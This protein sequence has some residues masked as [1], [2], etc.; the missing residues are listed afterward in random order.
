MKIVNMSQFFLFILFAG[1]AA[2]GN[3]CRGEA[4]II[5][6]VQKTVFLTPTLC[7]AF[8]DPQSVKFFS[9]NQ[10]CQLT[11]DEVLSKG[12]TP[13]H[14]DQGVCGLDEGSEI[15]GVIYLDSDLNIRI[16]E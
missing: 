10:L 4:Q 9:S 1:S 3:E 8:I 5:A 6:Q 14:I 7:K 16:E 12:I 2:S 15:N 13:R 11:I